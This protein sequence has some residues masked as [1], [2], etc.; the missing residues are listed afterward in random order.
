MMWYAAPLLTR[1]RGLTIPSRLRCA[2]VLLTATPLVLAA[3]HLLAVG[4]LLV[5][6]GILCAARFRFARHTALEFNPWDGLAA[7]IV[8]LVAAA[9]IPRA[10]DDGD[11]LAYHLPNA[12]AWV[13]SRSLDPTWMRYWWYPG[14]SEISVAGLIAACG[15]WISG[16]PSLLAAMMLVSRI[17]MWLRTRDVP[18]PVATAM[19]AAFITISTVAFQT[20]DQRND[21]VLTAW[22]VES[23]WVLRTQ[24]WS[25]TVPIAMLALIKPYGWAYA[26]VAIVCMRQPRALI[27]LVP[28]ALW[29]LHDALLAAHAHISIASTNAMGT[30]STTIL[31]NIPGSLAVLARAVGERGPVTVCCFVAPVVALFLRGKERRVAIAGVAALVLFL[32]SPFAYAN[33]MPQLALGWSLR[34]DLPEL[35]IGALC[36]A[37][38]ARK[39][40]LPFAIAA[41]ISAIAGIARL[42]YILN[43]DTS[44]LIA[45]IGAC[46]IVLAAFVAFLRSARYA[47]AFAAGAIAIGLALFGAN[48]ASVRAASSYAVIAPRIAGN[49]TAF[50]TWFQAHPHDA[51]SVNLRA[52]TLLMLAPTMRI[53]DADTVDCA[54]VKSEKA[55]IVVAKGDERTQAA[56]TCGHVI[57]EDADFIAVLPF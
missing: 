34:Y 41:A 6:A 52:G 26:L 19:S 53:F 5:I 14:G 44:I 21:L 31:G 27:G 57:F 13:Q 22:F 35:A 55:W 56:R 12:I 50:F 2:L 30:W 43:H 1:T 45:F 8:L 39:L 54:R 37:P 16:V 23:L 4:P 29:V 11:S 47:A 7:A 17:G 36:L 33:D 28:L 10:P 24:S 51:E 46:F 48:T 3:V 20:Y 38:L 49:E 40:P 42:L 9:Y 15:L 25:G 32:L 18:A